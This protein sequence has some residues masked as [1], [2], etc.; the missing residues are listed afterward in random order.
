MKFFRFVQKNLI[1]GRQALLRKRVKSPFP[2]DLRPFLVQI[3]GKVLEKVSR[4]RRLEGLRG[5]ATSPVSRHFHQA[6]RRRRE[7][8]RV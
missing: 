1:L 5:F 4:F 6:E 8:R 3:F 2:S 7:A